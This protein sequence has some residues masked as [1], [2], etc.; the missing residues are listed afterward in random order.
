MKNTP[1]IKT[2]AKKLTQ[3]YAEID[4]FGI[5]L[6]YPCFFIVILVSFSNICLALYL[7]SG[8]LL[9]GTFAIVKGISLYALPNNGPILG[10]LYGPVGY[11]AYLPAILGKTP[12]IVSLIAI[13]LSLIFYLSPV[14]AVL[15]PQKRSFKLLSV[16]LFFLVTLD[17]IS[18][19]YNAFF[20]HADAPAICLAAFAA[21]IIYWNN[22]RLLW[23]SAVLSVLS[24]WTK[25][26]MA[27]LLIALPLSVWFF[28]GKSLFRRYLFQLALSGAVISCIFAVFFGLRP[29]FFNIFLVPYCQCFELTDFAYAALI[30]IQE[31]GLILVFAAIY[32]LYDFL[33]S[34]RQNTHGNNWL[35]ASRSFI[36]F[37]VGIFL[38]PTSLL[39][40]VKPGG[41]SN[42]LGYSFYFILLSVL[43]SI[44][45]KMG[46]AGRRFAHGIIILCA[47][48]IFSV[49]QV[50]NIG[51]LP[52]AVALLEKDPQETAYRYMKGHPDETYFPWLPVPGIMADKKFYHY[53]IGLWDMDLAGFKISRSHFQ[54]YVPIKMKL[55][56]YYPN[57]FQRYKYMSKYLPDFCERIE[58]PEL[59]GWIV[60]KHKGK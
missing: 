31:L 46:Q 1:T 12:L 53:A 14:F 38:M 20:V 17:R 9:A 16:L 26:T 21:A 37:I 54:S 28:N 52:V 48:L 11:L 13:S 7:W 60:F 18:L 55:V 42:N 15:A 19:S 10:T 49:K 5:L 56:A 22:N 45:E 33:S 27:P 44:T 59:P 51:H 25:Q 8:G 39:A 47:V 35:R 6:F 29:I 36:F 34:P 23:L 24:V 40:F 43:S 50:P 30:M 4:N 2:A 32:Y 58:V 3:N 41:S 57:P